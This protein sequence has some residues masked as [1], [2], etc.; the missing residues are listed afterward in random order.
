LEVTAGPEQFGSPIREF[1]S[2]VKLWS[3]EQL[4]FSNQAEL[5]IKAA[6][7]TKTLAK[8]ISLSSPNL[9]CTLKRDPP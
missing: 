7:T 1:S 3:E 8:T 2:T 6:P 9:E 4:T 5:V